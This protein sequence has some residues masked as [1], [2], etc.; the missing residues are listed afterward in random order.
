MITVFRIQDKD[1]YG[2]WKPGFSDVWVED[3]TPTE[4]ATL[5]PWYIEFPVCLPC[6]PTEYMGVACRTK[7]QLRRWFT[8]NEY[9]TLRRYG[10]EAVEMEAN[11]I[12]A[13]SDIQCVIARTLPFNVKCKP[14]D[15]YRE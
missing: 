8:E 4:M 6:Q 9:A 11:R 14:F 15:L 7:E 1:G 13:G 2:P 10:Y 12:L 3:R 5:Q